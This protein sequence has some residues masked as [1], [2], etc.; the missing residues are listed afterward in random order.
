MRAYG[1]DVFAGTSVPRR[2]GKA[3]VPTGKKEG[4]PETGRPRDGAG[5]EEV[6]GVCPADLIRR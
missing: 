6:T 1:R 2:A 3:D 5:I 4:P